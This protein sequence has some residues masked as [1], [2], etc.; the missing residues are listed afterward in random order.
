KGGHYLQIKLDNPETDLFFKW[1][2]RDGNNN[3]G[4]PRLITIWGSNDESHL[5]L[6]KKDGEG[7]G[8]TTD[9]NAWKTSWDSVTVA[10][11][12]YPY[13]VTW[14]DGS[15]KANA[16]GTAY[17]K[18]SKAYKFLRIEVTRRVNDGDVPGG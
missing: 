15:K 4:S 14:K 12:K 5:E 2:K 13:E 3:N 10:T 11:F 16:A 1:V 8:A 17:A 7:E 18:L 9:F 6:N